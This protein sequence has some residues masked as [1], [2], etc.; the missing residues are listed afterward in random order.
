VHHLNPDHVSSI[1]RR[2]T[3]REN[4]KPETGKMAFTLLTKKG[5][6]QQVNMHEMKACGFANANIL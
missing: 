1:D 6:R 4:E 5:N 3:V 2:T